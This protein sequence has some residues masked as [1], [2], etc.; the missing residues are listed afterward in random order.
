MT[1]AALLAAVVLS[2][3]ADPE[4]VVTRDS[5]ALPSGCT[6]REAA[7]LLVRFA[8]AVNAG[9]MEALQR[10]VA[11]EE[12]DHGVLRPQPHF[13]WYSVNETTV[14]DIGDLWPYFAARQRQNERWEVVGVD[15][16]SSSIPGAA[17]I[18]YLIRRQA[19]D[20]PPSAGEFAFG[21]GKLDCAAQRIFVWSMAHHD[22][23]PTVPP[24]PLPAGWGPGDSIV[25]CARTGTTGTGVNART[26]LPDYCVERSSAVRFPRACGPRTVSARIRSALTA[27][28]S[29]VGAA[30]AKHFT[31]NGLFG[32]GNMLRVGRGAIAGFVRELH[33]SGVGWTAAR[34]TAPQW[35]G[36]ALP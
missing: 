22:S 4:I 6:P 2:L 19:D 15:V 13:R 14:Y 28:N 9:D 8:D 10:A 34:L 36:P 27:L 31:R 29:G 5:A 18:T 17:G 25:A 32:P 35:V 11:I 3:T 33:S 20:V 1:L 16:G 21:K 30:F 7:E 23:A 12:G 26:T 24:C